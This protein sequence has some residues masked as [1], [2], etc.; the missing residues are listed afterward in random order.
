[1][2]YNMKKKI[3]VIIKKSLHRSHFIVCE[4]QSA[5]TSIPAFELTNRTNDWAE[6]S[7]NG[8]KN[9]RNEQQ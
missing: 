7:Q 9:K 6:T 3:I 2:R 8:Q 1:M 4:P 5:P